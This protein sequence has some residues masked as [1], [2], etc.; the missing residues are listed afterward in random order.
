MWC[1]NL[2]TLNSIASNSQIL[3]SENKK[4]N[5]ENSTRLHDQE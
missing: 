4:G 1:A 3:Q 5:K 2:C